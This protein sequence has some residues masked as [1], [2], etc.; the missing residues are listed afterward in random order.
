MEDL[1]RHHYFRRMHWIILT[2]QYLHLEYSFFVGGFLR[3][4]ENHVE[5]VKI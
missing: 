4:V 5:M 1:R 3:A 2:V